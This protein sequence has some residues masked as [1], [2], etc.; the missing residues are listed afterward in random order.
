MKQQLISDLNEF[1]TFVGSLEYLKDEVWFSPL[2]EGKWRIHD[3]VVHI[4]K[5]DDYF[6]NVTF[7]N[8]VPE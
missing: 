1:L 6:N 5:W 8:I 4:M 7:P 3:I 2:S